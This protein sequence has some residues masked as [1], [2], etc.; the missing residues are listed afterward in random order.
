M[1]ENH[2]EAAIIR[3]MVAKE[4]RATRN[5]QGVFTAPNGSRIQVGTPG[6]PD[7]S[8]R[9]TM[10]AGRGLIE[11]CHC[12]AK[13]PGVT[14]SLAKAHDRRQLQCIA[15]LNAIGEPATWADTLDRWMEWYFQQGF[16]ET[17]VQP[18]PRPAKREAKK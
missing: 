12:E 1:T 4:W 11:I 15:A 18:A 17:E 9:R 7:W 6:Y 3:W 8:F 5:N 10:Q 14:P 16:R 2:T 13:K